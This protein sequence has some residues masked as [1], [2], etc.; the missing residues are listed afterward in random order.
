MSNTVV[1][2]EKSDPLHPT[3][4]KIRRAFNKQNADE[5]TTFLV[6]ININKIDIKS[7]N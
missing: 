1:F 4:V 5:N 2:Q 3:F 7:E 6:E